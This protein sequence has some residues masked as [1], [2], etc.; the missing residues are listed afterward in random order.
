MQIFRAD[1]VGDIAIS[2]HVEAW[3]TAGDSTTKI[4]PS[5][6]VRNVASGTM[7]GSSGSNIAADV[8]QGP[9]VN[10]VNGP[11]ALHRVRWIWIPDAY[12]SKES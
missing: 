5:L 9:G 6:Q 2:I 11:K 3:I 1:R 7:A 12:S 4:E 10:K 8:Y